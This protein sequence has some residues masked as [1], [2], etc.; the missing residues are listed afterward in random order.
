MSE[1]AIENALPPKGMDLIKSKTNVQ[2]VVLQPLETY[3]NKDDSYVSLMTQNLEA[4]TRALGTK[5]ATTKP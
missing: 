4:L 3:D 1:R 5:P 2:T